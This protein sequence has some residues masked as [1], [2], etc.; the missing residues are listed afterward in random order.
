M[1]TMAER[2][3]RQRVKID[4]SKGNA[5]PGADYDLVRQVLDRVRWD[6]PLA[7]GFAIMGLLWLYFPLFGHGSMRWTGVAFAC[8]FGLMAL[9]RLWQHKRISG[10]V[11]M[12]DAA[13]SGR[14][15]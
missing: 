10:G 15:R 5:I 14:D 12:W 7:I 2:R 6:V 11:A 1:A 3:E 13:R 8:I 4:L 9:T